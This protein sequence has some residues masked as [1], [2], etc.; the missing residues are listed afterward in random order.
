M[1][2]IL[3]TI[4]MINL[5]FLTAQELVIGEETIEPGI[6]FIFEGAIFLS[7]WISLKFVQK[8]KIFYGKN[9]V[10]KQINKIADAI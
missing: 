9:Y 10:Q 4:I 6:V 2:Y 7:D 5:N 3:F 1:K 8:T